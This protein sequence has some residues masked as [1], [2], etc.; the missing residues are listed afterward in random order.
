MVCLVEELS[1]EELTTSDMREVE[2]D[3]PGTDGAGAKA[4]LTSLTSLLREAV[5]LFNE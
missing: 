2:S 1:T 5:I 3:A 4:R